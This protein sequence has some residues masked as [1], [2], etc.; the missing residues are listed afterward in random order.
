[1]ER[2]GFDELGALGVQ[3]FTYVLVTQPGADVKLVVPPGVECL[4]W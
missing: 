3:S 4:D 1:M 2:M